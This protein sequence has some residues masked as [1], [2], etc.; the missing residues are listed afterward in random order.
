MVFPFSIQS[1]IILQGLEVYME[2]CTTKID[3]DSMLSR[4]NPS[5]YL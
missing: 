3:T 1:T 4:T 5:S 2:I